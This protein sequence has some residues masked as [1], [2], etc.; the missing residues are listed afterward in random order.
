MNKL[1][2]PLDWWIVN[3]RA[4]TISSAGARRRPKA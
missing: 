1:A 2:T 3:E 4:P